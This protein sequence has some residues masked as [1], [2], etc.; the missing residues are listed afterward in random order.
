MPNGQCT[1]LQV[2]RSE[3]ETK[4]GQCVVFLSKILY[5]NNG[6]LNLGE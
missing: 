3:V 1:G 2:K 6:S 5:F 4:P